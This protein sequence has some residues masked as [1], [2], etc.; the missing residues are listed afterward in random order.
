MFSWQTHFSMR[1]LIWSF[2]N[3]IQA[4]SETHAF[5]MTTQTPRLVFTQS[6]TSMC[7][8]SEKTASLIE[9]VCSSGHKHGAILDKMAN[10]LFNM[11][12]KNI[13]NE[14]NSAQHKLC[15]RKQGT[16][17][18]ASDERKIKKLQSRQ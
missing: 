7:K 11:F 8:S 2:Y 3:E 14:A 13:V 10:K 9:S 1:A 12:A 16:P 5:L 6:F 18:V 17:T 4:S 15:K